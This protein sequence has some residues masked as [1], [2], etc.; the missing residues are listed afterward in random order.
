MG[1]SE[2]SEGESRVG[3]E[4]S[5]EREQPVQRPW[6]RHL[7]SMCVEQQGWQC[8]WSI[9]KAEGTILK[10]SWLSVPG[11]Y[12]SRLDNGHSTAHRRNKCFILEAHKL[13]FWATCKFPHPC[14]V[15]GLPFESQELERCARNRLEDAWHPLGETG[16]KAR[17]T[18]RKQRWPSSWKLEPSCVID[19]QETTLILFFN[20]GVY[21]MHHIGPETLIPAGAVHCYN[22]LIKLWFIC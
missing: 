20:Y 22:V 12:L 16:C 1:R 19:Y 13:L 6:G 10:D 2:R 9:V 15:P 21:L 4:H 11:S 18:D 3:E 5:G 8:D 14:L 7:L 17:S